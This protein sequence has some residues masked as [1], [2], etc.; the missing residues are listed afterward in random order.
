MGARRENDVKQ[1]EGLAAGTEDA[2]TSVFL[3][4]S[5]VSLTIKWYCA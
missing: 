2:S 5:I 3:E 4:M 1:E